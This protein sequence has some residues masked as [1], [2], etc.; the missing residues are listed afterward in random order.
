MFTVQKLSFD[1]IILRD[2]TFFRRDFALAQYT[3][4]FTTTICECVYKPLYRTINS[5][6]NNM[7]NNYCWIKYCKYYKCCFSFLILLFNIINSIIYLNKKF[8]LWQKW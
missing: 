3:K 2:S 1:W 8:K 5:D 7:Y 6:M 4:D